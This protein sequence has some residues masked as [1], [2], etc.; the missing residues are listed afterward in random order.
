M[1]FRPDGMV[2]DPM[3]GSGTCR[4]VCQ[5]LGLP[6][7]SWDIHQGFDAC[8]PQDFPPEGTFAFIWAHPPYYRQKIMLTT[9]GTCRAPRP[10]GTS[11]AVTGSSSAI[12]PEPSSPPENSPC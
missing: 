8:D 1:F 5:E 10:W 6:C 4:D 12:V 2:F 7:V 3:Q 9:R 11:C